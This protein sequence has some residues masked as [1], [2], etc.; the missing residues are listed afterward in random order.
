MAHFLSDRTLRS[1]V[2]ITDDNIMQ[3]IMSSALFSI[4]ENKYYSSVVLMYSCVLLPFP[5]ELIILDS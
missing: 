5:A 4:A 3:Y 2:S 1:K